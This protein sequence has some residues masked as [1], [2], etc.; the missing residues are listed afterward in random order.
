VLKPGPA[1][2]E[3]LYPWYWNPERHFALA[4]GISCFREGTE[5]DHGGLSLQECL[6][7]EL[8]VRAGDATEKTAGVEITDAVW[9]GLRCTVALEGSFQG[10]T[11][12]VRSQPGNAASS[13]VVGTKLIKDN[14]TASVVVEKEELEGTGA[15]I[16]LLDAKGKLVAMQDTV[17]GKGSK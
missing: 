5:Y 12:D 16:V 4:D 17:I 15:A 1:T 8:N 13:K 6:T 14:G 7:I 11:L 10:L 3:R 9:K 2:E